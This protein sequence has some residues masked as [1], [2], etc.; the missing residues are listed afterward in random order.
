[1]KIIITFLAALLL[2]ASLCDAQTIVSQGSP[3]T[4]SDARAW[5]FKVVF[6]GVQVDPR[7]PK[8]TTATGTITS[9]TCP[10]SG[11]VSLTVSGYSSV[12]IQA[13]GTWSA[14]LNIE[15]TVGGSTW[16]PVSGKSM[17]GS[18]SGL[19]GFTSN[20]IYKVF[21]GGLTT[22]RVRA[23]S[24]TSGTAT[25]TMRTAPAGAS[26]P[27]ALTIPLIELSAY[28]SNWVPVA[29]FQDEAASGMQVA[30]VN[31][32]LAVHVVDSYTTSGQTTGA[33]NACQF[34]QPGTLPSNHDYTTARCGQFREMLVRL[35]S[36]NGSTL[37]EPGGV[38]PLTTMFPAGSTSST[39]SFTANA[40][41][42][43]YGSSSADSVSKGAI[44]F[45]IQNTFV[46]TIEF[47]GRTSSADSFSA[48]PAV[49]L[50][51]G[52]VSTTATTTG[53]YVLPTSYLWETQL[54]TTAWTSGQA[55]VTTSASPTLFATVNAAPIPIST[56]AATSALQ[57]TGNTSL[58]SIDT[59]L[60]NPLPVSVASLP[61]P[62]LAATSTLQTTGN[63]SLSSI[64]GKTP[65][66]GQALAAA[67]VPV[68]LPSATIT[69]LTPPAAITGF[70]LETGGNL[71]SIKADV[72]KIP[73]Q[74]QALAAGSTPVV[75]TAI[76]QAALTPPAAITG[77]A[78]EAG[79][80]AT[81]DTSTA[82]I[83]SQGQALAAGSM[84]VVLTAIQAAALTPPTNTG[85][86]LDSS[87]TTLNAKDFATQ[88]T[89]AAELA[90]ITALSAKIVQAQQLMANSL[91]VTIASNQPPILTV[92]STPFPLPPCNPVRRTNCQPKG[93]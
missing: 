50:T 86:A 56:G 34:D 42:Q 81:I 7:E 51:T 23:Q 71:A 44:I 38:Y 60:T 73:S 87:L 4:T 18:S 93:F 68:I 92:P 48:L 58:A 28:P 70:A 6:G 75:L 20:D 47:R 19:S 84:P 69:T 49:N 59:K 22:L 33:I 74:G 1:M 67:S 3:A 2:A 25:I 31:A 36:S 61:L 15:G 37:G 57:T 10:G 13:T 77:F 85:Y 83:P 82:K 65:A 9:S 43:T 27:D 89:L 54:A 90:A 76:Q 53:F 78:L 55:D 29:A 64:D 35:L 21:V 39:S 52:A 66:L 62:A 8:S 30:K 16:V 24:Y 45:H 14:G 12:V 40:Q 88:T 46:G 80:L 5:P 79:H 32:D 17:G 63:N 41:T 11:C 91:S 72:D 26:I